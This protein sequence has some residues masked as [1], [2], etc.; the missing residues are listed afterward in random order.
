[1]ETSKLD[2]NK[3][4]INKVKAANPECKII[5]FKNSVAIFN[6]TKEEALRF[7]YVLGTV[8]SDFIDYTDKRPKWQHDALRTF[9]QLYSS[10]Y[11]IRDIGRLSI[12]FPIM[13]RTMKKMIAAQSLTTLTIRANNSRLSDGQNLS[14]NDLRNYLVVALAYNVYVLTA[15]N[16]ADAKKIPFDPKKV[17]YEPFI[18]ALVFAKI[19]DQ[20]AQDTCDDVSAPQGFIAGFMRYAHAFLHDTE[21]NTFSEFPLDAVS[22]CYKSGGG[23]LGRVIRTLIALFEHRVEE[24]FSIV[25]EDG[26]DMHKDKIYNY[27]ATSYLWTD[28]AIKAIELGES[29]ESTDFY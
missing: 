23:Q 16:I 9:A 11:D 2:S 8:Q 19:A 18:S 24:A 28:M 1:V 21:E 22:V 5:G 10:I 13:A 20:M 12:Q 7:D 17:N 29:L 14:Q 3:T 27:I 6:F 4:N 25:A 15:K 26:Q